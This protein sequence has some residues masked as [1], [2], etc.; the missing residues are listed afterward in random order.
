MRFPSC[1]LTT[2][3]ILIGEQSKAPLLPSTTA[4]TLT[5]FK[6]NVCQV[7]PAASLS[8]F[9][10]GSMSS[11]AASAYRTS[12]AAVGLAIPY[13]I[14]AYRS[15]RAHYVKCMRP[16]FSNHHRRPSYLLLEHSIQTTFESQL[17]LRA[18]ILCRDSSRIIA[19]QA[20]DQ[21]ERLGCVFCV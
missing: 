20:P 14:S 3:D 5:I 16:M 21:K 13:Q 17:G 8:L 7:L 19:P 1:C 6:P 4:R 15:S 18:C 2:K 11:S 12:M 9:L 10:D